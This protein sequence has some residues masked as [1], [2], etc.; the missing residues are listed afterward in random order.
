VDKQAP[1][2]ADAAEVADRQAQAAPLGLS[3]RYGRQE[4]EEQD[5]HN[6]QDS[7]DRQE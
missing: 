3:W 6:R 2:P 4:K 7:L 5:H 1:A